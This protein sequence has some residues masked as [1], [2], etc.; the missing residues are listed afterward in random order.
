MWKI[1]FTFKILQINLYP[2]QR[3]P[4]PY[5]YTAAYEFYFVQSSVLGHQLILYSAG[6]LFSISP[7]RQTENEF[8]PEL[9]TL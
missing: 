1:G 4:P 8:L 5:L 3:D 9:F 7:R 2:L 6:P